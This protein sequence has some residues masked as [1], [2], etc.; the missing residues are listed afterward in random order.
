MGWGADKRLR[1]PTPAHVT[2]SGAVS[3]HVSDAWNCDVPDPAT[4]DS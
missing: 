4:M 3:T 2:V 1:P